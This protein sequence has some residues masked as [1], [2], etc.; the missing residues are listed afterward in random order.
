MSN[1]TYPAA[2]VVAN[3]INDVGLVLL[4]L[5]RLVIAIRR[6]IDHCLLQSGLF[7]RRLLYYFIVM[8]LLSIPANFTPYHATACAA[9]RA[10]LARRSCASFESGWVSVF[11]AKL[12][13]Q[14]RESDMV[15]EKIQIA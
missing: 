13:Q 14:A 5:L 1:C 8:P 9:N 7:S 15:S 3:T 6:E 4:Q 12:I 11:E 10:A 2:D